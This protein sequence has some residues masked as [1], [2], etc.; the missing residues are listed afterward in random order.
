MI[1]RK[2]RESG[3]AKSDFMQKVLCDVKL[4]RRQRVLHLVIVDAYRLY[5]IK[6]EDTLNYRFL[7]DGCTVQCLIELDI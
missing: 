2:S 4:S 5:T 6:K 1:S 3:I 7:R